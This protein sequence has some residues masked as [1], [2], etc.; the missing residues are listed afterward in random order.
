MT[1]CDFDNPITRT[2]NGGAFYISST[3]LVNPSSIT[4]NNVN[5]KLSRAQGSGGFL[6]VA[7]INAELTLSTI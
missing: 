1:G 4:F 6:N 5:S 2:N 3:D 7:G